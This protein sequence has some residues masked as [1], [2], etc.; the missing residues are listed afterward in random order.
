MTIQVLKEDIDNPYVTTLSN[1]ISRA[2]QRAT[3]R[4]WYVFDGTTI[5]QMRSPL[6]PLPLPRQVASWWDG[7]KTKGSEVVL[8]FEF[9][10]NL[11]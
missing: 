2:L 6:Q 9:E 3:G 10:L 11:E 7:Y 4:L 5:R 8:P 1:P